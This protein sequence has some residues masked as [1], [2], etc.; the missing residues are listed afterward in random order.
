MA[1]VSRRVITLLAASRVVVEQASLC[2]KTI[3]HA[4]ASNTSILNN[5]NNNN[6]NTVYLFHAI[7]PNARST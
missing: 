4:K 5:N 6:N 3:G 1:A 7:S 2:P